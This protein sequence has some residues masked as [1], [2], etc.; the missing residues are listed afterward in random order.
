I[1]YAT[2]RGNLRYG[3]WGMRDRGLNFHHFNLS[4][5]GNFFRSAITI[6]PQRVNGREDFRVWNQQLIA[7]A[8][9]QVEGNDVGLNG[10]ASSGGESK[11]PIVGDHI[12]TEFTEVS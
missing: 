12:N 5:G 2:N 1:K 9:Y 11:C 7:Y 8:G 3:S 6:F 10:L 4:C